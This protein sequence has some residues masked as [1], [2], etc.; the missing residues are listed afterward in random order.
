MH[1]RAVSPRLSLRDA[2]VSTPSGSSNSHCESHQHHA[3]ESNHKRAPFADSIGAKGNNDGQYRSSDVNRDRHEL[4]FRFGIVQ[5]LDNRRQEQADSVE[6]TD[7]LRPRVSCPQQKQRDERRSYT[8][9]HED[10]HPNLPVL[11]RLPDI[12]PFK[13][14]GLLHLRSSLPL[15][16]ATGHHGLALILEAMNHKRLLILGQK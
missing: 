7:N 5:A 9:V 14:L 4:R 8:P 6:W 11:E 10:I 16:I 1:L 2:N 12:L 13:L 15:G 3:H